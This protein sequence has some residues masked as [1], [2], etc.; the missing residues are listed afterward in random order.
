[1]AHKHIISHLPF[2]LHF[3][4][5][6]SLLCSSTLQKVAHPCAHTASSDTFQTDILT[7]EPTEVN[8]L[9]CLGVIY[10]FI[11]LQSPKVLKHLRSSVHVCIMAKTYIF[12]KLV[13]CNLELGS[14]I[15]NV[16]FEVLHDKSVLIITMA[17]G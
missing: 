17:I 14:S 11:F 6:K 13:V 15:Q 10:L 7:P 4:H 16:Y 9:F 2:S 12:P 1:M 8:L 3:S 5:V